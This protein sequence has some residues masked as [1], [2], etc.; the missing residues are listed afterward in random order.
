ML[1]LN[2]LDSLG[3]DLGVVRL[4][5]TGGR[6]TVTGLVDARTVLVSPHVPTPPILPRL[7]GPY[8]FGLIIIGTE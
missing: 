5:R 7:Q 3:P 8:I 4:V 6:C 2:T 1:R